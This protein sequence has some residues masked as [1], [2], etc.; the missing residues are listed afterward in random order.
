MEQ[1]INMWSTYMNSTMSTPEL[2]TVELTHIG[3][4]Y[5]LVLRM[6]VVRDEIIETSGSKT[7]LEKGY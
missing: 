3:L 6:V 2:S 1:G 7:Q 4:C 5:S